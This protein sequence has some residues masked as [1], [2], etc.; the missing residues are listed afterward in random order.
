M[1]LMR[2]SSF[3][4]VAQNP[5]RIFYILATIRFASLAGA[6]AA[7]RGYILGRGEK[8]RFSLAKAARWSACGSA[9]NSPTAFH[10]KMAELVLRF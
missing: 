3:S 7:K 8:L 5:V 1:E 6:S 4:D 10:P 9:A 2:F